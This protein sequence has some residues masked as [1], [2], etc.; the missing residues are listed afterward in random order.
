MLRQRKMLCGSICK[1]YTD[2]GIDGPLTCLT[3]L[4][5]FGLPAALQV[6]VH[7]ALAALLV[8]DQLGG[9]YTLP[10]SDRHTVWPSSRYTV[11]QPVSVV[12]R[13]PPAVYTWMSPSHDTGIASQK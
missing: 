13:M 4:L 2:A 9:T 3:D 10:S 1:R 8:P 7:M 12:A 6:L 5:L 11:V